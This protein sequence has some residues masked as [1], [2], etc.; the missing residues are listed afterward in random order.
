VTTAAQPEPGKWRNQ[1][2]TRRLSEQSLGAEPEGSVRT[3]ACGPVLVAMRKRAD[4][5]WQVN[6]RRV[7]SHIL[8]GLR[9][10]QRVKVHDVG[11]AES[12]RGQ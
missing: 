8:D 4:G 9:S 11:D 10:Y 1:G 3:F 12:P 7:P 5:Q 6:P 2:P